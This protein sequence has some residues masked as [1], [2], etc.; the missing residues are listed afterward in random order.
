MDS[1]QELGGINK[2]SARRKICMTVFGRTGDARRDHTVSPL[3]AGCVS[4]TWYP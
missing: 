1:T 4:S 3:L 2:P